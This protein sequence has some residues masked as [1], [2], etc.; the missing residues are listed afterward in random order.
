[1]RFE[2]ALARLART[3]QQLRSGQLQSVLGS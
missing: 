3:V 1:M 2:R